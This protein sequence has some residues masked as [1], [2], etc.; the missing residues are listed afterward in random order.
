MLARVL[1]AM[2]G[3]WLIVSP[4]VLGYTGAAAFNARAMGPIVVGASIIAIAQVMRPLRWLELVVGG[5]LVT[6]PWVLIKWYGVVELSNA[7]GV[8]IALIILAFLGGNTEKNSG[9]GW[10]SLVAIMPEEKRP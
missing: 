3:G 2:L 7:V 1:A 4:A 9:G 8:G 5:W 10:S 6:S